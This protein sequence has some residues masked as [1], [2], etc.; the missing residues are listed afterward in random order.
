MGGLVGPE[1]RV[2]VLPALLVG[3]DLVEVG[4]GE[5]DQ[6]GLLQVRHRDPPAA[7]EVG[8]EA[9]GEDLAE[10]AADVVLL[11]ELHERVL[12]ERLHGETERLFDGLGDGLVG[13]TVPAA[14]ARAAW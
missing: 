9:V 12:G 6:A 11:A 7:F 13:E 3:G 14:A 10:G 2:G 8:V 1:H 5:A 4:V